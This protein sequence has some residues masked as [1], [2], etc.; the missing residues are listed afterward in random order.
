VVDV[1][2]GTESAI[3]YRDWE[4]YLSVIA[5]HPVAKPEELD[6]G[7]KIRFSIRTVR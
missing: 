1:G 6:G 4:I 2:L 3:T 7:T 5:A